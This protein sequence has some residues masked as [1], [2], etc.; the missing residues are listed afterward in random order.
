[1]LRAT[2]ERAIYSKQ[3]IGAG[4]EGESERRIMEALIRLRELLGSAAGS[5]LDAE[6]YWL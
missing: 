6:L 1:M 2:Y 5:G 4:R 3:D